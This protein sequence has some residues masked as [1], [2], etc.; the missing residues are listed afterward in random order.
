MNKILPLNEKRKQRIQKTL[1]AGLSLESPHDVKKELIVLG[2]IICDSKSFLNV[3]LEIINNKDVFYLETHQYV[4]QAIKNLYDNQ[5]HIDMLTITD[6]L[7]KANFQEI[8]PDTYEGGV[9][10]FIASLTDSFVTRIDYFSDLCMTL[11]DRWVRRV[12]IKSSSDCIQDAYNLAND[13]LDILS[14]AQ[15][16]F[17]KFAEPITRTNSSSFNELLPEIINDLSSA[18]RTNKFI[19]VPSGLEKVDRFT[20]GFQKG[21]LIIL[22]GRPSMGKTT[23]AVTFGINAVKN[24]NKSVLFFSIES[25]KEEIAFKIVSNLSGHSV[26]EVKKWNF[27]ESQIRS[28]YEKTSPLCHN[29]FI[30]D[31][32]SNDMSVIRSKAI[33]IQ[34]SKKIDLIIVDYLQLIDGKENTHS[35]NNREQEVSNISR[36]LKL[37]AKELNI[38]VIALAQLSRAVETRGGDKRPQLS[39]LRDSGAIEQNADQVFFLYRPWYYDNE[40]HSKKGVLELIAAKNRNG[41]V[42]TIMLEENLAINNITNGV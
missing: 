19:G 20:N 32:S 25:S 3:F 17:S 28:I 5:K 31:D 36:K 39:D 38:P 13:S 1:S 11:L 12:I 37:L 14:K 4:Y 22:A 42:G 34:S 9:G 15:T 16:S 21:S 8:L 10:L 7:K 6:E 26:D 23:A 41:R 18:K 40:D 35:S 2:S 29:N 27:S 24:F 30:I 33:N